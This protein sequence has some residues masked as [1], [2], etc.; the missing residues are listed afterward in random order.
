MMHGVCVPRQNKYHC[1]CQPRYS[2][3][4]CEIDNGIV[5][6]K[7]FSLVIY[8]SWII[9]YFIIGSPCAKQNNRCMHG[10]CEEIKH[11]EDFICHCNKGFTGDH[12]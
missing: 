3:N 2:G 11:G 10:D 7:I 12:F 5:N 6:H 4:N 1:I 9:I 8:Q